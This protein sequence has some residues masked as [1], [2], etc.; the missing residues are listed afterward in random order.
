VML[1]MGHNDG[2]GVPDRI[3]LNGIG[4]ETQDVNAPN[5]VGTVTLHTYGWYLRKY[6]E[7]TRLRKATIILVTPVLSN[8]WDKEG[9]NRNKWGQYAYWMRQVAEAEKVPLLDL[10]KISLKHY[11]ELG[12]EKVS[13]EFYAKGDITHTV[14]EGAK[15][16]ASYVIEGLREMKD[17]KLADFL[18]KQEVQS[19]A[20]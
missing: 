9:V 12:K 6:V 7:D 14:P 13:S 10:N 4:E 19:K 8:T 16:N 2:G 1:Q 3:S 20:K 17:C 18:K 5:G 15:A 11:G